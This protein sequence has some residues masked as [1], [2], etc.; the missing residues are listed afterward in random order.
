MSELKNRIRWICAYVT[1][2]WRY[3]RLLSGANTLG[4]IKIMSF[5]FSSVCNLRCKYC[6]LDKLDRPK[7]LD[8][9]IYE[10]VIKEVS[11]NKRYKVKVIE[12]P[13]SGEF[14]VYP[15]YQKVIEITKRYMD[16]NPHFR[17]DII[18]N[19]NLMLMD[20]ERMDLILE[21][22]IVTQLICSVDGHD[23]ETF[24]NMRP[25]AKFNVILERM[26]LLKQ[27]NEALGH[28]V[29]IQVNNGRDERSFGKDFSPEMKEILGVGDTV[30]HWFPQ[31]WNES[32]NKPQRDYHPA[33]GFCSFV[34]NN[35]TLS[36]SGYVSKCCMDLRGQ[37]EYADLRERSLEDIWHSE[38]RKQFL[39]LMFR[40]KRAS[41]EGCASC[42][43]TVVN[44]DNRHNNIFRVLRRTLRLNPQER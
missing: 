31:G 26:R 10:K 19:E 40:N 30:T 7:T 22:G 34:F 18:L 6:F 29:H 1:W 8:I 12:W 2:L 15:H 16:Q 33:K 21:S 32:F 14:F 23:A 37:T 38:T 44:N 4:D 35:V 17:P 39:N 9:D 42:S 3:V 24:E 43:L 27:K 36:S 28:P 5:E 25:P 20:E 13:I 11:E 41:L